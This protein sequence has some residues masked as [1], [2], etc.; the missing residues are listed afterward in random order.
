MEEYQVGMNH[1][2]FEYADD[3]AFLGRNQENI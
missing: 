2:I 1:K 3:I